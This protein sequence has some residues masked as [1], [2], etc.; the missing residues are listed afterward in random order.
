MKPAKPLLQGM[1]THG[2]GL[3]ALLLALLIPASAWLL[4]YA[5]QAPRESDDLRKV[6]FVRSAAGIQD[7]VRL[8]RELEKNMLA[9]AASPQ[10]S[11][12]YRERREAVRRRIDE[13]A[14]GAAS[15]ADGAQERARLGQLAVLVRVAD[16]RYEQVLA[17]A[18]AQSNP[19]LAMQTSE[20]TVVQPKGD[21]P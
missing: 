4:A 5:S 12:Y 13:L 17:S 10:R 15:I 2:F 20:A 16:A 3:G 7:R 21:K 9:S 11:G 1:D 18:R 6:E 14:G 19:R 8:L